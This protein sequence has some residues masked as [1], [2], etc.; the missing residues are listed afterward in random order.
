VSCLSSF[1]WLC[2]LS[3]LHKWGTSRCS[4]L[5]PL[6]T[7]RFPSSFSSSSLE[8]ISHWFGSLLFRD[9]MRGPDI[10]LALNYPWD[11]PVACETQKYCGLQF[12]GCW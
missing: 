8:I 4:V 1:A 3:L 10:S 6:G 9:E 7:P 2:I 11:F 12:K 5:R